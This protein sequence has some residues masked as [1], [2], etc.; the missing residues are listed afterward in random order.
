MD[1][2]GTPLCHLQETHFICKDTH[3]REG[4]G[5]DTPLFYACGNQKKARGNYTFYQTK[6]TLKQDCNERQR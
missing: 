5:K 6:Q 3:L 4:M 1:K 2:K